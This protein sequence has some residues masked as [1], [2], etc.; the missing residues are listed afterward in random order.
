[1]TTKARAEAAPVPPPLTIWT[2]RT[3]ISALAS[4]LATE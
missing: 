4:G 2:I 3:R 1:M